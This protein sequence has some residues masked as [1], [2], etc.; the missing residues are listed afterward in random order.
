MDSNAHHPTRWPGR[1]GIAIGIMVLLVGLFVV[2]RQKT[3]VPRPETP[4]QTESPAL[5][6]DPIAD[7]VARDAGRIDAASRRLRQRD[8]E[9]AQADGLAFA[10][11]AFDAVS[12]YKNQTG[13]IDWWF[14]DDDFLRIEALL[15]GVS[16]AEIH[17]AN[18]TSE[19]NRLIRGSDIALELIRELETP[20]AARALADYLWS[21]HHLASTATCDV[22]A[23][24]VIRLAAQ[25]WGPLANRA[26][27]DQDR[28]TAEQLMAQLYADQ[29]RIAL[30]QQGFPWQGSHRL[31]PAAYLS[32]RADPAIRNRDEV[33]RAERLRAQVAA[34][35]LGVLAEN[36]VRIAS[37]VEQGLG[38]ITCSA[39]E[40][41]ADSFNGL[42]DLPATVVDALMVGQQSTV[43][44][45]IK[46]YI[47]NPADVTGMGNRVE[48][49]IR[50]VPKTIAA[51]LLDEV[52]LDDSSRSTVPTGSLNAGKAAT[53]DTDAI[54]R[55]MILDTVLA[56]TD[57]GLIVAEGAVAAGLL[58]TPDLLVSK[59]LGVL[60]VVHLIADQAWEAA[61]VWPRWQ[62]L[63]ALR[64]S[65]TDAVMSPWFGVPRRDRCA[66]DQGT[67]IVPAG[68]PFPGGIIQLEMHLWNGMKDAAGRTP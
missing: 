48:A 52:D 43:D 14:R 47:L 44:S 57:V 18:I 20:E 28:V 9:A 32:I 33:L 60:V 23:Y 59:V 68:E 3:P 22:R 50:L 29:L 11:V 38:T 45:R 12:A 37:I 24:D 61:K 35:T 62:R 40:G 49:A 42:I 26:I 13:P 34:I 15:R 53:T 39:V 8:D 25:S 36:R 51:R 5:T 56:T 27:A 16:P 4:A 63:V 6:N 67:L 10:D 21:D 1:T 7:A 17:C 46:Q 30:S 66:M 54:G 65:C 19:A 58:A 64:F 41:F 31:L 2:L 55:E